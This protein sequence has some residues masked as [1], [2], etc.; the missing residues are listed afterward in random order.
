MDGVAQQLAQ[1]F[2]PTSAGWSITL[3]PL[4]LFYSSVRN[5]R[6]T[7]WVLF[8]AVGVLLLIAC[9]NLANLLLARASVRSREISV[10]LALGA[11]P[12]RVI[13]QLVTESLLLG[14]LGGAAGFLLAGAAFRSLMAITPYIPSFR[15]DAI[16]VDSQVSSSPCSSRCLW[17]PRSDSLRQFALP[18]RT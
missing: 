18:G 1:E 6:L 8:A 14:L 9:A 4:Q 17:L 10:R 12:G 3:R 2:P 16:R 5:I 11:A 7:L 15:P 13:R